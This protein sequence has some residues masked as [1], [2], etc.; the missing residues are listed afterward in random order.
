MEVKG[1]KSLSLGFVYNSFTEK[2]KKIKEFISPPECIVDQF[3]N[4]EL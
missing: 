4:R 3:V 2:K 1:L